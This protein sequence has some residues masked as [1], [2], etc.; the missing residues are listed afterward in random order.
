MTSMY[1]MFWDGTRCESTEFAAAVHKMA[2]YGH[3]AEFSTD[4]F[5]FRR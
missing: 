3:I 5:F 4:K 2:A 1:Q